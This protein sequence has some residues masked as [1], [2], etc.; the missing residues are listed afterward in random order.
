MSVPP[1]NYSLLAHLLASAA[2]TADA[3][4]AASSNRFRAALADAAEREGTAL[5][6]QAGDVTTALSTAGYEPLTDDDGD[7]VLRNG[8][9]HSVVQQHPDLVCALNESFV[10]GTLD[11]A[12]CDPDR[13]DLSPCSGR[14]CVVV[15]PEARS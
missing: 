13:A 5:G 10:R 14:C 12:G 3:E 11:G 6:A 15:H 1:R 8:P 7:I 4:D 9:F 2:D